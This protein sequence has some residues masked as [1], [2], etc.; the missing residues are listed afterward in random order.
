MGR[1]ETTFAAQMQYL[2]ADAFLDR[3]GTAARQTQLEARLVEK[4]GWTLDQIDAVQPGRLE[5]LLLYWN[6]EAEWQERHRD[7]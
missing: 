5:R 3:V 2:A 4:T 1:R 6:A 7:H